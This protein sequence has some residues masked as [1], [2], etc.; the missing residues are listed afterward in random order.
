MVGA[1]DS[2]APCNVELV[3]MFRPPPR[4]ALAVPAALALAS[5]GWT[6]CSGA[7]AAPSAGLA[8]VRGDFQERVLL[9]GELQS[10]RSVELKVPQTRIFRLALRAVVRDGTP[11]RAGQVVA[12]F[13]N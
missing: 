8:A 3:G 6:G 5:I 13:D 11:V 7:R 4:R 9:T 1:M 10:R 2:G 12:E